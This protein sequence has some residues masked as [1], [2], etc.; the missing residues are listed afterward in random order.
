MNDISFTRYFRLHPGRIECDAG[1][2]RVGGV[3]LLARGANGAW[4]K[5]DE[6]DLDREL[7]KVYGFPLDFARMRRGVDAVAA[8]L[9]NGELAR[10]QIAALLLQ[11]PDPPASVG[12]QP[13]A[14]QKR[15]LARDLVVCGLLKADA[16][17]D[18][19]HPR[20]GAP[21]NPGWLAPKSGE[22]GAE[23]DRG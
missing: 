23:E 4:T 12:L 14:L 11:L 16:D 2:L 9:A 10:A 13:D 15:R 6:R 20:T 3:A 19:K 17:W 5:R 1:G 22:P 8:A 7:S 18:D 21:P